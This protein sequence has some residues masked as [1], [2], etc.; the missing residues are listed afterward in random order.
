M[1]I[2]HIFDHFIYFSRFLICCYFLSHRWMFKSYDSC[3]LIYKLSL[4]PLHFCSK[5]L[6][7]N[8]GLCDLFQSVSTQVFLCVNLKCE[9]KLIDGNPPCVSSLTVTVIMLKMLCLLTSSGLTSHL[10]AV[11]LED[12]GQLPEKGLKLFNQRGQHCISPWF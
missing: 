1:E 8:S 6:L 3:T 4:F 9:L 2:C 12:T 10:A 11:T 7:P 5:E